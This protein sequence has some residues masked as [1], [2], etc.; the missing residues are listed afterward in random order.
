M[1]VTPDP[2]AQLP[3]ALHTAA[4]SRELDRLAIERLGIPGFELMQ[5]A[6]RQ[7]FR[8]LLKYWPTPDHIHVCCGTGNNG[9]D[10]FVIAALAKARDIPVSIWQVG[11]P[12][13]IRGDALLARQQAERAGVPIA[14]FDGAALA[15][16][17]IVDALLGT[18]LGGEV[19]QPFRDAIAAINA[20]GLPVMAVD[21]P[22]GLCSDRGVELGLA[23]RAQ[24]TVTFIACKQ[25][26]LTGRGP[27]CSGELRFDALQLPDELL[28]AVPASSHRLDLGRLQGRLPRRP[29][30]AHKGHYGHLLVVGGDHGFGGAVLMAAEAAARLGAGLTSCATRTEH[31]AP[32]LARRPEV[33]AAPVRSGQE[34]QP[35][36]ARASAVVIGPGLG[37]GGWGEQLLQAVLATS[38]PLVIDADGLNLLARWSVPRRDTWLLTPHPGEAARLLGCDNA[39]IGADRF[40]AAHAL[41][42]RYGGAVILKGSGSLVADAQGISV[43]PYGNPGM[44]S[45]GMGDVLSGVLGALLAQGLSVA[46]A[47]QLG[48]C[49]HG[50]AG[51]L[52]AVAG[53]RGLLA[54]DLIPPL[55]QLANPQ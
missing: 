47:A 19:R 51:D 44:A 50:R 6:G 54:T 3:L 14:P 21:I 52:A 22:S 42:Q 25:G 27:A 37:Q 17:V 49:L 18:G 35:L 7:A 15:Q 40:A 46:E 53:E 23:V 41:Q 48:C 29:R 30:D 32:L 5:R 55:R 16:G 31:L 10:G 20:S 1:P 13:R 4:G 34:L 33:M 43:S 2:F 8:M 39:A 9:G 36:L 24:L 11:D 12:A 26:L 28:A 45:G 38:L